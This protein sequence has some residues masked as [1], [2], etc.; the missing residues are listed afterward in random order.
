MCLQ[1]C[2]NFVCD[3]CGAFLTT[4]ISLVGCASLGYRCLSACRSCVFPSNFSTYNLCASAVDTCGKP[5]NK[6]KKIQDKEI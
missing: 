2:D 5:V 6:V 3:I 1:F 4:G